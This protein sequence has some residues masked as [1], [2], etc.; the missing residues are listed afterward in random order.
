M[1]GVKGRSRE[2]YFTSCFHLYK[3]TLKNKN[4]AIRVEATDNFGRTYSCDKIM[5]DYEYDLMNVL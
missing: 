5:A 1:R 4:A 2:N 3:Y